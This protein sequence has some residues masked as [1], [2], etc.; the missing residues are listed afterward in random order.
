MPLRSRKNIKVAIVEVQIE[1]DTKEVQEEDMDEEED[2]DMVMV[3]EY[4][5]FSLIV[6]KWAMCR[7]FV[8]NP[9]C[10]LWVL[11]QYRAC[12]RIF[13]D[14]LAKWEEKKAHCNMV[15]MEPRRDQKTE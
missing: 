7:D 10:S 14:L 8:L 3:E 12:Q 9:V 11:S 13:S 6:A 1:E 2:E 4:H 15:T 5:L